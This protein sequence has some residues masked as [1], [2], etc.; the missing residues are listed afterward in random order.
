MKKIVVLLS[1]LLVVGCTTNQSI[2]VAESEAGNGA[3]D[4]PLNYYAYNSTSELLSTGA[5]VAN[6]YIELADANATSQD[7]AAFL[8]TGMATWAAYGTIEGYT[9]EKLGRIA[10][11]GILINQSVNYLSPKETRERLIVAAE[12]QFCIV[13][14]GRP[15]SSSTANEEAHQVLADGFTSVRL[16][17]RKELSREFP[18]FSKVLSD[19]A[20]AI[21]KTQGL[22]RTSSGNLDL[23]RAQIA[24]CI[25][26]G[27]SNS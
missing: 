18:D 12:R 11:G 20:S 19:Y 2:R 27:K 13:S 8:L 9:A 21:K 1:A 3:S 10:L 22:A 5:S 26:V 4:Q 23:L 7:V 6:A 25:L 24:E 14:R 17:L 15:F 16:L